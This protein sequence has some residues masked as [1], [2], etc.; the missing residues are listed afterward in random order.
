MEAWNKKDKFAPHFLILLFVIMSAG[1][2]TFGYLYYSNYKTYLRAEVEK[3]LSSIGKLKANELMHWREDRLGDGGTLYKNTAF[4][5]LVRKYFNDPND[6][7]AQN[8]IRVWLS[9][10]QTAHQYDGVFLLDNQYRKKIIVPDVPERPVSYVSQQSSEILQSGEIALE[11]FYE[12]R[13]NERIYLKVLVPILNESNNRIIGVVAL[14]T[15]PAKYLYPL[16]N[17]WP[18]QNLSAETLLVRREGKN[19]RYLNELKFKQG[20]ALN[21]VVSIKEN[22]TLAAAQA[23][24]GKEGIVEGIDYRG[25]PVIA[26]VRAVPHSPWFLVNRMDSSEIFTPIRQKLFGI[27]IFIGVL[28]GGTGACFGLV[29]RWQRLRFYKE[30]YQSAKEWSTTFDSITDLVSIVG[31]DFKLKKTN[32]AFA[33]VLGGK[34]EDFVGKHCYELV[35][36]TK[37]PP[38]YCPCRKT[39]STNEPAKAETFHEG[40]NKYLEI[41]TSPV[42]NDRKEVSDVVHIVR[43]IT[44]RKRAEEALQNSEKKYRGLFESSC[45]AIMMLEPPTWKFTS[46]NPATLKLFQVDTKEK[47]TSLGPCDISPL[48]QPDGRVSA[49]KAK[50]MIEK[51]MKE[52]SSFFEWIHKRINGEDF[53]V[54]VLLTRMEHDK[55]IFVQATV[56]DITAQKQAENELKQIN[57]SLKIATASASEMAAQAQKANAAKS[58]FLAN[59]SHEIRTPLNSI[60]GFTEILLREDLPAQHREQLTTVH[61]SGKHLLQLI[62]DILDLSKIEAG[63][64]TIEMTKCSLADIIA[65]VESMMHPFAAEKGI[66]FAINEKG[67]LPANILTDSARVSQCLINLVNNAIKFTKQGHV[68]V[69]ISMK[70]HNGKWF[71]R[72]EVEDTGIGISSEYQQK[73]FESFSQEDGSTS[74]KHGGTGLGLAITKKFT[75]LFGGTITLTSEKDKG[76]VF[77]FVIPANI[78]MANQPPLDRNSASHE[79]SINK[80]ASFSGHILVAE[81]IKSNQMLMKVLLE[82]M[83]LKTTLADNGAE[84][85][86]KVNGQSFDLIFMDVH[87]PQMDGYEATRTLRNNGIKTP[88]VALTANAMEGDE[89]ECLDAG[90]DDYLS[91]PVIYTKLVAM[92]SKFLGKTDSPEVAVSAENNNHITQPDDTDDNEVIINWAKV[93]ANGIDEQIIKEVMPTYLVSNREH[94]QGLITAVKAANATDVVSHAHAIKG[95]GRNLGMV[96][97]SKVVMQLEMMARQGD[98]SKAEELLKSVIFEFDRLEKFVSQPDWVETAKKSSSTKVAST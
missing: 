23:V 90:C 62:S 30:K 21:L 64:M 67:R 83:G 71:I 59:M 27:I 86:D 63:K 79:A 85:V 9:S 49:D 95:A 68:Y 20:T 45:D 57:E 54:T 82:K 26:D 77:A 51:A 53:P 60:I 34:P 93:V 91:K 69:N 1:I 43:D 40:L 70:D 75:E 56:R 87:M 36:N 31:S 14:R 98:L 92:L 7:D 72:F 44:E 81:D 96:Q 97:L 3:Q 84:A 76:S 8:Q 11:D 19:I 48:Q 39:L 6:Q 37:E 18:V 25:V 33:D 24:L 15:D 32:K 80:Q 66:D 94:M 89:K 78:D 88:I 55:R 42:L 12:N 38:A 17:T 46:C 22:K 61:N 2:I 58:E 74:R 4:T 35:H 65:R 10:F 41:S 50:E 28:L 52:G 47:F 13:E 73:M 29:W 5:A 16:I